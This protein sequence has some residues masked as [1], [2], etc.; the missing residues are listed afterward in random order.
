MDWLTSRLCAK[1]MAVRMTEM[2]V[3]EGK[4]GLQRKSGGRIDPLSGA[5]QARLQMWLFPV[6]LDGFL[7][8]Q[9]SHP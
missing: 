8:C 9:S 1:V 7:C 6:S 5:C 4:T 2:G 3:S